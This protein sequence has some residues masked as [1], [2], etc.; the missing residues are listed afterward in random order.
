M[1][2]VKLDDLLKHRDLLQSIS[3][4]TF[5]FSIINKQH[6]LS[7]VNDDMEAEE[8]TQIYKRIIGEITELIN[9][10]YK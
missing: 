1:E 3:N 4:K 5:N 10:F 2:I 6:P 7:T 8:I 9:N